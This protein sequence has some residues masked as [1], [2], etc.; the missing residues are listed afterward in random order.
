ME[1]QP[2]SSQAD[3]TRSKAS[4]P[5]PVTQKR[6]ILLTNRCS[7][8]CKAEPIRSQRSI[9][10]VMASSCQCLR[11]GELALRLASQQQR[12]HVSRLREAHV[13]DET[14]FAE[15]VVLIHR[16]RRTAAQTRQRLRQTATRVFLFCRRMIRT[17][18]LR[19]RTASLRFGTPRRR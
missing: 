1:A 12:V 19:C 11:L 14:L 7:G 18:S 10:L 15:A 17:S 6:V 3:S 9:S 13:L 16:R 4:A 2:R 8:F 5:V